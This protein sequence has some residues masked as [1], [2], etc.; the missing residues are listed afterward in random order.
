MINRHFLV[1]RAHRYNIES[2]PSHAPYTDAYSELFGAWTLD[3]DF[4][5]KSLERPRPMTKK[6]DRET[7]EDQKGE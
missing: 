1:V 7:G 3:G 2:S 5:V 4:L 6:D